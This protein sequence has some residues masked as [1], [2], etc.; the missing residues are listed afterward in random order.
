[1]KKKIA[2]L[3]AAALMVT[4][5]PFYALA[6]DGAVTADTTEQ[7]QEAVTAVEG[8]GAAS[9]EAQQTVYP[10]WNDDHTSY[11]DENGNMVTGVVKIAGTKTITKKIKYYYSKK[12]KKWQTSKIKG[13]KTKYVKKK[14][15]A[16]ADY[17]YMFGEDGVLVTTKGVFTYNGEEYYGLGNGR[18]KTGWVAI[19]ENKKG[20]AVYFSKDNGAMAKNTTIGHLKVPKNG[21]LGR[22]YYLGVKRLDKTGWSLKK[23]YRYSSKIKYQGRSYRAKNSETYA[24][25]GFTKGHGNCYVMAA[26]FYIMAKLLGYDVHQVE[27]KVDL[28]HSWTVIKQNGKEWVYDPNFTNETGRNGYKI[29]YGK[30]GTWRY[31]HYH[32]MN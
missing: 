3:L 6:D 15:T 10:C 26:T 8:E 13:A 16:A 5:M 20:K 18:L 24:I 7:T 2:I 31:N 11:F 17:L 29:Y 21:R 23:A 28:P 9:G 14:K 25:K 1:M 32:K 27:G 22:A 19:V 12:K 4:S 30:K